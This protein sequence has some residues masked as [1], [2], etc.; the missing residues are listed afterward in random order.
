MQKQFLKK[1]YFKDHNFNDI[2]SNLFD[3]SDNFKL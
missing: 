3:L 2:K 1:N